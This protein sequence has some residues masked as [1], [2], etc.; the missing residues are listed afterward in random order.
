MSPPCTT[1]SPS[2]IFRGCARTIGDWVVYYEPT[3]VPDTRGYYAVA[4][5]ADVVGDMRASE[6]YLAQ[7]EPGTYLE[8]SSPVPFMLEDGRAELGV[9]NEQGRVSGRAQAAVRP[10][11]PARLRSDRL[12]RID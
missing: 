10:L 6:M 11:S 7:I 8:F 1:N 5:V 12:T 2:N 9:L 4:K 3:K